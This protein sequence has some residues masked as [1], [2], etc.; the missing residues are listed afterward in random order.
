MVILKGYQGLFSESRETFTNI[1]GLS[2]DRLDLIHKPC[3]IMGKI[4]RGVLQVNVFWG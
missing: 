3:A 1:A 2:E 4:G